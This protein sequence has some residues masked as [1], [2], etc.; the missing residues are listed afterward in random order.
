MLVERFQ[1]IKHALRFLF[2]II[3]DIWRRYVKISIN[4]LSF[5]LRYMFYDLLMYEV[6]FRIRSSVV[7]HR[8]F[9]IHFHIYISVN[10]SS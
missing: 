4:L 2:M 5:S 1:F 7:I 8:R 10:V 6:F 3:G 9:I